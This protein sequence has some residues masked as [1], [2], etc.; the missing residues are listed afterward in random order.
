MKRVKSSGEQIVRFLNEVE[1]NPE[2]SE[3]GYR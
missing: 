3:T 2:L 1:G